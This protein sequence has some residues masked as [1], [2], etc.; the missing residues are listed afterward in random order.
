M[1]TDWTPE[2][3]SVNITLPAV[4]QAGM[5]RMGGTYQMWQR[6]LT[7]SIGDGSAAE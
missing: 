5:K 1:I 4:K 6:S 3:G 7:D 2:R